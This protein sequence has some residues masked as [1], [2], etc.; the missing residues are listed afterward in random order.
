MLNSSTGTINS[1]GI[2][3]GNSPLAGGGGSGAGSINIFVKNGYLNNGFLDVE[4]GLG[5]TGGKVS[6][7]KGGT[8]SISVGKIVDGTYVSEYTNY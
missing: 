2:K 3:G 4:G 6:G 5:G 8:G 7:G 1:N